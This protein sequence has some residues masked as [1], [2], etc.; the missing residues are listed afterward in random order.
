ML[1]F[2][3]RKGITAKV[4]TS[5]IGSAGGT[6]ITLTVTDSDGTVLYSKQISNGASGNSASYTIQ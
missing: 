2:K 3:S 1:N 4:V 6:R 5:G